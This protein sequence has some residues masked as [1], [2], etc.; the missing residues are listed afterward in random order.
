MKLS[1]K[2]S[3]LIAGV[4][5]GMFGTSCKKQLD[6]NRTPNSP[7]AEQGTPKLVFPAAVMGTAARV[8]GDLAI[9]GAIWG[10]YATQSALSSQYRQLDAY[11]VDGSQ[12]NAP[13]NGLFSQG[14]KN[15]QF[16]IDKSKETEDWN[17]YLMAT[18]MKAYTMGLLV[19]LYD[20]VPYTEALQGIGNLNP[21][22]DDGQAIY[23]ALLAELDAALAKDFTASTNTSPGKFDLVFPP[24]S[25]S[26]DVQK[27]IS[28]NTNGNI[29]KWKQFANTLK[30][31][32]FLRMVNK[33]AAAAQAGIQKLYS[34]NVTFLTSHAGVGG[35]TDVA[36]KDNPMYE[37]NIRALNTPDNLRASKTL[38]SYL[39]V[40]ADPRMTF[41]YG[42]ADPIF[43]HQG[44]YL[45]TDASL[46]YGNAAKLAQS[47]TDPVIFISLAES[48]LMQA[49]ARE[50]YFAGA[51]AKALYDAGVQ[52]S[53]TSMGAGSAATLLA[54]AYAYPTTTLDAKI[55][56][57]STQKW[58][59]FGYGV[60][61]IEGFFEKQR[62]GYPKTSPVYSNNAAYVPGQWVISK[63]TVLAAGQLPRRLVFPDVEK[64]RNS[65][66][67]AI[68]PIQ[69]GVW[70][71]L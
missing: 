28:W 27:E 24:T 21:K 55:E 32:F 71:A 31:K 68:V 61:Y 1:F 4:V 54:G 30:L 44:D 52:A 17:F 40:N 36:G 12:L 34:D 37:Q 53:F 7:A 33:N 43:V 38:V 22:F 29:N 48:L 63:N 62:T 49:E 50:R 41:F 2:N 16:I 65:N 59:A 10:E 19:D 39:K 42:V 57:I 11:N 47:P 67:P 6:I 3:V 46:N 25:G 51:G 14:L 8:G 45:N 9:L 15:Y 64:N 13:Y 35:F 18:T 69:T 60:H 70:W 66:T 23:T 5:A 20:K 58:I 56:A 26:T